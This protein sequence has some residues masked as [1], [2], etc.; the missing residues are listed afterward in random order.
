[1][2]R[3]L[4]VIPL[5]LFVVLN[6]C[7]S[8]GTPTTGGVFVTFTPTMEP[9]AMYA[10]QSAYAFMNLNL[11]IERLETLDKFTELEHVTGASYQVTNVDFPLENGMP[12]VFQVA[13][14][15]ECARNAECCSP[16][17]TFV[18]TLLAFNNAMTYD[19][20]FSN[21]IQQGVPVEVRNMSVRIF[22]HATETE[23]INV[24]WENVKIFLYQ[25][26]SFRGFE[27]GARVTETAP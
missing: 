14:R 7:G 11:A 4:L 19:P 10:S 26:D 23:V 16:T 15:C 27:L 22:D 25:P 6:A 1:M 12:T 18:V 17:R 2:K 20:N 24:P 3:Y 8:P 21:W 5:I 9:V 13:T